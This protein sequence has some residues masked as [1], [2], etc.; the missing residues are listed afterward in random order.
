MIQTNW[1]PN[2][3]PYTLH[4]MSLVNFQLDDNTLILHTKSGMIRTTPPFGRLDGYLEFHQVDWDMSYVYILA[5]TGNEG[6][7]TGRKLFLREFIRDFQNS[8]FSVSDETYGF[9][10]TKYNGYL[11]T[12]D[13]FG[14]CVIE[15]YHIGEMLYVTQE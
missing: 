6:V 15:I 13:F 2:E 5:F 11:K 3:A 8:V 10:Q 4:D 9:N 1:R 12:Q 14:E 7:F